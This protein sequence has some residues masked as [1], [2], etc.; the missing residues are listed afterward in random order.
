MF[1]QV[2]RAL[3]TTLLS[4]AL[5]AYTNYSSRLRLHSRSGHALLE[6]T[7]ADLLTSEAK[8]LEPVKMQSGATHKRESSLAPKD[9]VM[10]GATPEHLRSASSNLNSGTRF[11][12]DIPH[13]HVSDVD[14]PDAPP[15][16][17]QR[18]R[19]RPKVRI[20]GQKSGEGTSSVKHL[21]KKTGGAAGDA[22]WG[23]G[24]RHKSAGVS[25]VTRASTHRAQKFPES[26]NKPKYD[27]IP[28]DQM[29]LLLRMGGLGLSSNPPEDRSR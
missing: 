15:A 2:L 29:G 23:G 24:H 16:G 25:G 4:S 5:V 21:K 7:S 9:V 19:K 18:V 22:S 12:Q 13:A 27:G 14:M 17:Q 8:T 20:L 10:R 1:V 3:K 28:G 6:P 11:N 26:K